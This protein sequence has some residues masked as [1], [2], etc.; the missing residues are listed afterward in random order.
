MN[1]IWAY[2]TF[3]KAYFGNAYSYLYVHF[4]LPKLAWACLK[5]V[6]PF[7]VRK[8][9]LYLFGTGDLLLFSKTH[10]LNVFMTWKKGK[11]CMLNVYF[12]WRNSYNLF[13]I[14]HTLIFEIRGCVYFNTCIFFTKGTAWH[15]ITIQPKP[16]Q[17][18]TTRSFD[19][20]TTYKLPCLTFAA[21]ILRLKFSHSI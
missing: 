11:R 16:Q 18:P 15:R 9:I 8:A 5:G 12:S 3:G 1:Q 19:P 20:Q 13:E 14:R 7:L 6:R 21:S 2:F 4:G 10:L 17:P